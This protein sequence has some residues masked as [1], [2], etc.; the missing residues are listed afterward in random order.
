MKANELMIGDWVKVTDDDTDD[1]F[2][3]QVKAIDELGNI[4]VQEGED[5]AYPY[6]I[7]CLEPIS[8]TPDIL[9]KNGFKNVKEN[10]WVWEEKYHSNVDIIRIDDCISFYKE[11]PSEKNGG[12][13]TGGWIQAMSERGRVD[14]DS[15]YVHELQHAI[16]QCKMDKE[17]IL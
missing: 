5:V 15:E 17:I 11:Y 13:Q 12:L 7:D 6:S 9:E 8:L 16:H 1:S 2:I 14:I 4:N 3:G 10:Q